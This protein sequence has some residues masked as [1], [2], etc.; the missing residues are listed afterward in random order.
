[1]LPQVNMKFTNKIAKKPFL[2]TFQEVK[3]TIKAEMRRRRQTYFSAV[4]LNFHLV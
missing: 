4:I 3:N 2:L 1:M